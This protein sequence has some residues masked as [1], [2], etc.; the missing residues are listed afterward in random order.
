MAAWHY[1]RLAGRCANGFERDGGRLHH[2][3]PGESSRDLHHRRALC[4]AAPGRRSVGFEPVNMLD[5][6]GRPPARVCARCERRR[7]AMETGS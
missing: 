5:G 3:I 2:V 4:G 6:S 7:Q 1:A